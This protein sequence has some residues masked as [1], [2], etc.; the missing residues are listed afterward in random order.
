MDDKSADYVA[1]ALADLRGTLETQFKMQQETNELIRALIDQL[2][3]SGQATAD[4]TA[5]ILDKDHQ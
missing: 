1:T 3:Q 2:Q 4:L 5:A